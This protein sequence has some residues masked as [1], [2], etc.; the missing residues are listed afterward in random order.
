MLCRV[1]LKT[2]STRSPWEDSNEPS[3]ERSTSDF[4]QVNGNSNLELVKNCIYNE[5][6]MLPYILASKSTMPNYISTASSSGSGCNDGIKADVS[7]H[8]DKLNLLGAQ[9]VASSAKSL[10]NPMKRK[11]VE[12]NQLDLY[13]PQNNKLREIEV[14][15]EKQ[16]LE[17]DVS[18]GYNYNYF[19]QW[20]SMIQPQELNSLAFSGFI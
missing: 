2:S 4:Q 17:T 5:F 16:I 18:K 7:V 8:E 20:T 3:N 14:D 1:R 13:A 12:E 11:F 19:D 6:P 15:N 9:F 10:L